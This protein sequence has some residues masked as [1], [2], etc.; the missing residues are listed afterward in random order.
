[1]FT[2]IITD[3]GLVR[4][5]TRHAGADTRFEIETAYDTDEIEL[6]ASIACSGPCLT[7][8]DKGPGW[9]AVE[10]SAETLARTTMGRWTEGRPI[11]LERALAVGDELGGH[12]VTGHVDAVA[13]IRARDT[14]DGSTRF[15]VAVPP[16]L[17][18]F[19]AEKGSVALDGVSL[20]VNGVTDGDDETRFEVN[21]IRHTQEMT[22]FGALKEGDTVNLE[23][24]ILARYVG[25]MR[26]EMETA[27]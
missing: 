5:I 19:V 17:A 23:V 2:G 22:T 16:D 3:L 1:M 7:V 24:D 25:R 14:V 12:I 13:T 4:A 15:S 10:A 18:P 9:F 20:T 8:T 21:I 11:N 6:G 26:D 27:R